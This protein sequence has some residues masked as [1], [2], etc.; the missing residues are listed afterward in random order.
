MAVPQIPALQ[1]ALDAVFA[2]L[3]ATFARIEKAADALAPGSG[4]ALAKIIAQDEPLLKAALGDAVSIVAKAGLEIGD[5]IRTLH[6]PVN[7][8]V[9]DSA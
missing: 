8:D 7:P 5:A 4:A 1:A 2:R 3:D 9:T 6:A